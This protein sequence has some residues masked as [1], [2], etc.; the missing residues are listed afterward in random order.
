MSGDPTTD[1]ADRQALWQAET[2]ALYAAEGRVVRWIEDGGVRLDGV[3]WLPEPDPLFR[4]VREVERF[5]EQAC[6]RL[7]VP[8]VTV[9]A[10]RG[11]KKAEYT[12]ALMEIAIPP[13]QVGGAWALRGLVVVHELAHHL[14][15]VGGAREGGPH[16]ATFRT[17]MMHAL[18]V[19]GQPVNAQLL[20]LA[21]ETDTATAL[22]DTWRGR[23]QAILRQAEATPH[24]AEA[25]T[26]V[27]R[28]QE[29]A[30]RHAIDLA[31][32]GARDRPD[33]AEQ[34]ELPEEVTVVMGRPGQ[35]WLRLYCSLFMAV[36]RANDV[37]Y[38]L[39]HNS[40]RVYA[41]GMP[42][43]IATTV[44]LY[45][46]LRAQMLAAATRWMD[47][48]VWRSETDLR[49]TGRRLEEVPVHWSTAK[50]SFFEGFIDSVAQRLEE[51]RLRAETAS[52]VR[53]A[54][55]GPVPATGPGAGDGP[56]TE[57]PGQAGGGSPPATTSDEAALHTMAL[58]LTAKREQV[59]AFHEQVCARVRPGRWR[60]PDHDRA[61]YS[62]AGAKA[63][64]EAG[65]E[66][67]VGRRRRRLES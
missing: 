29:L 24:Q 64:G 3:T 27:A 40:T 55:P 53:A 35:R 10:R 43:D 13:A 9:R 65:R 5:C 36:A 44:A 56:A 30:T 6:D 33:G 60:G 2:A 16:G 22:Q 62:A 31:L 49:W 11:P 39:A 34:G 41:H 47:T 28:A 58:V 25:E 61:T 38:L 51:S 50:T 57:A 46:S 17:R 32:L 20:G 45:E 54:G 59:R 42:S 7:G 15:E 12:G 14:V 67:A 19:L 26:F 23:I 37:K 48:G 1:E 66:A 52:D 21:L 18:D 8:R 4:D 63:G